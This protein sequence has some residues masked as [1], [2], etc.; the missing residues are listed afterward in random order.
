M[1]KNYGTLVIAAGASIAA[2]ARAAIT[3]P[4]MINVER[5]TP[6]TNPAV[7][8]TMPLIE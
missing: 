7:F 6:I 8:M 5:I 2:F 3:V 4:N 1:A